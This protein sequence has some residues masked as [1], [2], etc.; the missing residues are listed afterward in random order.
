[1]EVNRG[2]NISSGTLHSTDLDQPRCA[3]PRPP[4]SRFK[5]NFPNLFV[6]DA[7]KIRNRHVAFLASF[8]DPSK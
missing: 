1:M 3:H 7:I 4:H 8:H 5:D 6:R 2:V